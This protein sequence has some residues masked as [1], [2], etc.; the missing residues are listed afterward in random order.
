MKKRLLSCLL[1]LALLAPASVTVAAADY[2]DLSGHWAEPYITEL[3]N[4]GY[5]TGYTDGTVK[6]DKTI[7]ACE[8]IAL[9]S[10]FYPVEGGLAE[11]IHEDYGDFVSQNIDPTLTWAYDEIEV[12]LAAGIL[13]QN[14]IRNLRLTVPV[15][16]ELLSVL[17]V[18]ALQ[19]TDKA[20]ALMDDGVELTFDDTDEIA[21][22]YRGH[23]AVLVNNKIVEGDTRNNFTPHAEVTRGV[24]AAM[25]VRGLDYVESLGN[26]L[27][28]P[29][30]DVAAASRTGVVTGVSG[31]TIALRDSEGIS[32]AYTVDAE[33]ALS[34]NGKDAALKDIVAGFY[35]TVRVQDGVVTSLSARNEEG[36]AWHMGAAAEVSKTTA[37]VTLSL[38]NLDAGTASKL[39]VPAATAVTING[40]AKT[41]ADL[42]DGMFLTVAMQ[43][44]K[45]AS[46]TAISGSYSLTATVASLTYGTPVSLELKGEDGGLIHFALDLAAPPTITRGD[47]QVSIERLGAGDEVTLT[48]EGCR[49]IKITAAANTNN[50]EG[51]LTSVISTAAGTTWLITDGE[52]GTHSLV[53]APSANAYQAGR[54]ILIS[55]IQVGDTISVV[56]DGK[57]I[58]EVNLRSSSGDGA[59]K[60][61]GTVLVT[62]S[63]TKTLTVLTAGNRLVYIDA[64]QTASIINAANGKSISLSG[65]EVNRSL[66]AYGS[67]DDPSNFNAKSIIIIPER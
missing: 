36:A 37:G 8:A 25:V 20:A 57:T 34:V 32:R 2:S 24:V 45:I 49:L 64:S 41:A 22:A 65:I 16:K 46:I 62:D 21:E 38:Q 35:V 67:Y 48:I 31:S 39:Q 12:C 5:M 27:S 61:S 10:R 50:L 17:L 26:E 44:D 29:G 11:L 6:P 55:T 42:S 13:S 4:L 1:A 33:S 23:I 53:V 40:A 7:T 30:Y 3:S 63:S 58:S 60:V 28:V 9:L 19:L 47:S 18:R 52:N 15:D 56:S 54:A 14:E 43:G 59:N 51:V 66:E